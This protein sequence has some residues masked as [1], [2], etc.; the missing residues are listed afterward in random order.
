MF[1]TNLSASCSPCEASSQTAGL[2][3]TTAMNFS[4]WAFDISVSPEKE[5]SLQCFAVVRRGSPAGFAVVRRHAP[6]RLDRAVRH[7]RGSRP[8]PPRADD[9]DA[10]G[11]RIELRVLQLSAGE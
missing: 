9:N 4:S 2:A 1:A 6:S 7:R 8:C 11:N 5:T 3:D 10:A